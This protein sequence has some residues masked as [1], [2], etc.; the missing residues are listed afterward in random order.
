MNRNR[1][2]VVVTA[3]A[4]SALTGSVASAQERDS[5]SER[6]ARSLAPATNSVELTIGTGY[7]QGFG[8]FASNQPTLADLGQAGGPSKRG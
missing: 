5:T 2:A 8:K 3:A 4:M 7:E 6:P 1:M